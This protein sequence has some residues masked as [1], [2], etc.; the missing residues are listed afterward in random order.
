MRY[1]LQV[2]HNLHGR[3]VVSL[4]HN[5]PHFVATMH[6]VQLRFSEDEDISRGS[7]ILEEGGVVG[8]K[9]SR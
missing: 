9:G 7:I 5:T 3:R 8:N 6:V 1:D 2:E 4:L